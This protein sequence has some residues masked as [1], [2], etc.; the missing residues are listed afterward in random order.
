MDRLRQIYNIL[1]GTD[2]HP[3][4]HLLIRDNRT[5]KTYHILLTPLT[6]SYLLHANQLAT[7]RDYQGKPLRFYDPGYK[8]TLSA[9]SSIC[10]IDGMRGHL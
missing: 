1:S 2:D 8:N 4:R 5:R 6:H 3:D 7:I 9:A 10:Y